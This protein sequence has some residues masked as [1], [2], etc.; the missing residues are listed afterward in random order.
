MVASL[1]V[2][3]AKSVG[4]AIAVSSIEIICQFG[5]KQEAGMQ[6]L[7]TIM[8]KLET[9]LSVVPTC[10]HEE[11]CFEILNILERQF[12]LYKSC[13]FACKVLKRLL[14]IITRLKLYRLSSSEVPYFLRGQLYLHLEN[15][16]ELRLLEV[17]SVIMISIES[18]HD[19]EDLLIKAIK[20]LRR[21]RKLTL[22]SYFTDRI[23]QT[24]VKSC[25]D[26]WYLNAKFSKLVTNKSVPFLIECQ[27]LKQVIL[28]HT[29]VTT[30]GYADLL[31]GKPDLTR[32]VT[33][34]RMNDILDLMMVFSPAN[35]FLHIT[36][37]HI[38]SVQI[39]HLKFIAKHCHLLSSL[40]VSCESADFALLSSLTRLQELAIS[41]ANYKDHRIQEL[42]EKVGKNILTLKFYRVDH[43]DFVKLN[44]LCPKLERLL[45]DGCSFKKCCV[46]E[47]RTVTFPNL[48][49]ITCGENV[50]KCYLESLIS[51]CS[52]VKCL[53]LA[54]VGDYFTD[55][56][57]Q[58]LLQQNSMSSLEELCIYRSKYLTL[59]TVNLIVNNCTKL[60]KFYGL[61]RFLAISTMERN[62]FIHSHAG[63]KFFTLGEPMFLQERFELPW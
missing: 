48:E 43:I 6:K 45:V 12:Y 11:L 53:Y 21:L 19:V 55:E 42:L 31:L 24:V 32:L 49:H 20:K 58:I 25:P 3:A 7:E 34:E 59:S 14:Q 8:E 30:S 47:M 52:A 44:S 4:H 63:I 28:E 1:K 17:K 15:L 16:T 9:D 40:S 61:E 18:I 22:Y 13:K 27:S 54:D 29:S 56:N 5:Q 10:L 46:P 51:K 41:K 37:L 33:D 23:A 50:P 39:E 57:M 35:L 26:L 62:N 60:K 36:S 2:Q 38:N